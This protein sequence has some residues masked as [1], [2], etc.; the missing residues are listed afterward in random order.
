MMEQRIN[1]AAYVVVLSE[2]VNFPM[3]IS[4]REENGR[5]HGRIKHLTSAGIKPTTP[6]LMTVALPIELRGQTGASL[7]LRVRH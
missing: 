2:P 5:P 4:P 1:S 3:S 7:L 6:D